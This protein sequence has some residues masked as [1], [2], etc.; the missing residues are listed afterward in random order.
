[1]PSKL[2]FF[3]FDFDFD[4]KDFDFNAFWGENYIM[5]E[6]SERAWQVKVADKAILTA[7]RSGY[8]SVVDE[9][10]RTPGE[11]RA[12]FEKS[13]AIRIAGDEIFKWDE[14]LNMGEIR[15]KVTPWMEENGYIRAGYRN[16]DRAWGDIAIT[17]RGVQDSLAHWSGPE[18]VQVFA[19]LPDMISGGIYI[20]TTSG[21]THQQNMKR[22]IFASKVNVGRKPLL[23]GFVI[24]EDA[25]GRR[26]YD[27]ELAEI[28]NPD[29]LSS[30]AGTIGLDTEKAHRTR[31]GSVINVI[32]EALKV[33]SQDEK[34]SK[35]KNM[36]GTK[37]VVMIMEG[38]RPLRGQPYPTL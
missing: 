28:N 12:A 35:N 27:H 2:L 32:Q 9:M 17:E 26:F 36:E 16:G 38:T 31:R 21:K 22:H 33:N 13:V 24:S 15:A 6:S 25:S 4:F 29:G 37:P 23:V 8:G 10:G 20:G 5:W 7:G 30:H 18:K 34:K 14:P 11:R 3:L 1:M 19:A